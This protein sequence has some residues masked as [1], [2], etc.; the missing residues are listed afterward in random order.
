LRPELGSCSF[1][2]MK[3]LNLG[4][5]INVAAAGSALLAA[6]GCGASPEKAASKLCKALESCEKADFNESFDS[7]DECEDYYQESIEYYEDEYGEECSKAYSKFIICGANA[8]KRD[9]A[10]DDIEDECEDEAD[11]YYDACE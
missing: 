6:S 1:A 7:L 2:S 8:Y 3:D 9:C 10:Y 5:M 4:R 11:E